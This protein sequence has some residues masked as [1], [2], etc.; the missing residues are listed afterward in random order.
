[1]KSWAFIILFIVGTASAETLD[2][3]SGS[4]SIFISQKDNWLLKR[5][6]FGM[7]FVYFSPLTHGQRSNISFTETGA[8]IE[9]DPSSLKSSEENYQ[10]MKN[11]WA[12]K[13]GA[14][15]LQFFP[16]TITPNKLGHRVHQIGFRYEHEGKTYDEKSFYIECRGRIIFAKALR[17][18]ENSAHD[19]DFSDLI[20]SLDCGGL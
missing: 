5:D 9:I 4:R 14:A 2:L 12:R 6:L 19:K 1:V 11:N 17:L 18:R 8:D 20:S 13:V 15:Q 16:Y 3:K 7:P 10:K